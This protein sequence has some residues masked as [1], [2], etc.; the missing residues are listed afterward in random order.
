MRITWLPLLQ[1]MRAVYA[2]PR[3]PERFRQYLQLATGGADDLVTPVLAFNPMAREHV[4][5]RL[6]AL[7]ALGGDEIAAEAAARAAQRLARIELEL[8]GG[9]ELA[10]DLHGGWTNRYLTDAGHRFPAAMAQKPLAGRS[11]IRPFA[12]AL[13]FVSEEY[14]G[15]AIAALVAEAVYRGAYGRLVGP[16]RTLE[17]MLRQERMAA[18]FAGTPSTAADEDVDAARI[19]MAPHRASDAW[20]VCFACLYGDEAAESV[21]FAPLGVP[22][23]GGF[24]VARAEARERAEDPVGTLVERP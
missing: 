20:P 15:E 14:T 10:D 24:A 1:Q 16:A 13:L 23:W 8:V 17:E 9:L 7:L 11:N 6:E 22:A 2:V 19:A 4:V 3:G 21:G 18:R 5:A 12:T